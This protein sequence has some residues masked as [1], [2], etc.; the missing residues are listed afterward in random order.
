MKCVQILLVVLCA[1]TVPPN[2][3]Y[4]RPPSG[5]EDTSRCYDINGRAQRCVPKFSNAAF[6]RRVEATN[7]CGKNGRKRYCIQTSTYGNKTCDWCDAEDPARGHPA[8]YLTDD[9]Q[10]LQTWWQ[11]DTMYD[12]I[13]RVNLTLYLG[14]Y[15]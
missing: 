5:A 10:N 4:T 12:G 11:S 8:S 7:E 3:G 14:A 13:E 2:A 9:N 6:Q 1:V 15:A